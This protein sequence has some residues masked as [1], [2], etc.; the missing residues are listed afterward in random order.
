MTVFS[1][2]ALALALAAP[3]PP[4]HV[5]MIPPASID[6]TLEIT[7]ESLAAQE[8]R[9]R[10]FIDVRVNDR[11]PFRFLV[12]SGADRSV[13]SI[14]LAERLALP[15]GEVVKLQGMAG[16]AQVATVIID[17]LSIGASDIIGVTAPTLAGRDLGA[18]GLIG[19]DALA[20]Q[21]LLLDFDAR[22]ITVQDSRHP[23]PQMEGEIT[24]TARRRKGQLILTEASVNGGKVSAVIDTGSEITL[25]NLALQRRVLKGRNPDTLKTITMI[26]V[27][28]QT[29]TATSAVL[30]EV[31]IG[32][33]L[34][35]N[36]SVAFADAPPFGLFGLDREPS[37]FL[38]ADLLRE[39][40][41]LSLD[42]RNRKVRFTL[43]H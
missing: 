6:N 19:I 14:A 4:P 40:K 39:F 5:P 38:G 1:I 25:G 20:D 7:G 21:R 10:L 34:M 8:L 37:L 13:I 29:L 36:V 2:A 35:Q 24:V 30:A 23:E 11:G 31:R 3:E 16:S 28:G 42:F 41:R 32:G 27:T 9:N 26:S 22:T 43:R 18:E 12:D 15:P 17:K 33:V